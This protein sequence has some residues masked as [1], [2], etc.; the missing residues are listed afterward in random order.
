[1]TARIPNLVS[2]RPNGLANSRQRL[3]LDDRDTSALRHQ[4]FVRSKRN[5]RTSGQGLYGRNPSRSHEPAGGRV[6]G[7]DRSFCKGGCICGSHRIVGCLREIPVRRC[8]PPLN[9]DSQPKQVSRPSDRLTANDASANRALVPAAG[10][11][12]TPGAAPS[13]TAQ[14]QQVPLS[15][16]QGQQAALSPISKPL[17][18]GST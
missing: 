10:I 12:A 4:H 13:A 17:G 11:A 7:A 18:Q 14:A 16:A 9:S 5:I 8:S 6:T 1:M 15:P 3:M 2:M